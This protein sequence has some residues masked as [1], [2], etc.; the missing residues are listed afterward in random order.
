[1]PSYTVAAL[2]N[3]NAL[4]VTILGRP[5]RWVS[6]E[7]FVALGTLIDPSLVSEMLALKQ[8]EHLCLIYRHDPTE[9]LGALL[10]FIS[11][12]LRNDEQCIYIADD[13]TVD[14]LRHALREYGIDVEAH[15][16][17]GA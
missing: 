8:G 3:C 17:S 7:R 9:Q 16:A 13:N 1:M 2:R 5:R 11:Q 15:E 14:E 4:D 12:G 6:E 10:P